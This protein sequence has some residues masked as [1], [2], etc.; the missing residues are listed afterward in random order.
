MLPRL[1]WYIALGIWRMN[2]SIVYSTHQYAT[3]RCDDIRKHQIYFILNEWTFLKGSGQD[4]AKYFICLDSTYWP[5]H[6]LSDNNIHI[7]GRLVQVIKHSNLQSQYYFCS[8]PS[9]TSHLQ[10]WYWPNSL[11]NIIKI[12]RWLFSPLLHS[13]LSI[14]IVGNRNILIR[15]QLYT[16]V[17]VISLLVISLTWTAFEVFFSGFFFVFFVLFCFVYFVFL[18][19]GWVGGCCFSCYTV[20]FFF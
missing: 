8:W 17:V 7:D 4:I 3:N 13:K 19:G 16:C 12:F 20:V 11:N 14:C 2:Q 6:I 1:W 15:F 10:V 9:A 18:G 5:L